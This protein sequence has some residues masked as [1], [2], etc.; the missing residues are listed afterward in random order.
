MY[1]VFINDIPL[2]LVDKQEESWVQNTI[3]KFSFQSNSTILQAIDKLKETQS[4]I[5][6]VHSNLEELWSAFKENFTGIVAAG[7]VVKNMNDEYLL[8]KRNGIWDL[9]KGKVEKNE[10]I[11][12]AAIR[13]VQEE[14]GLKTISRDHYLG[15]T[16][17][18]YEMKGK[19]I[20]KE[21]YWYRMTCGNNQ[22][23][24]PQIEEG[25]TEVIWVN[26][27]EFLSKMKSSFFSLTDFVSS[28]S[29]LL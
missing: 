3:F 8:I 27:Q 9:P 14:C 4:A 18:T 22:E 13:E 15:T 17:H 23:L 2:I 25:I 19:N 29:S 1:K 7:G 24:I 10:Q 28:I 26:R 6:I 11:E 20:L 21:T 5:V 12:L 16:Y